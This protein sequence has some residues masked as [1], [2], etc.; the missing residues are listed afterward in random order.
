MNNNH[1]LRIDPHA[2]TKRGH[3]L[4]DEN[5]LNSHPGRSSEV[6]ALSSLAK[7]RPCHPERS[8]ESGSFKILQAKPS[9]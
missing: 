8:E 4:Q 9:G 3:H 1:C 6:E 2:P 7:R 5:Q